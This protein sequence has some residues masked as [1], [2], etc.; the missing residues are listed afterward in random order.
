MN[1]PTPNNRIAQYFSPIDRSSA[2]K[3]QPP[4]ARRLPCTMA[5]RLSA[6]N[7]KHRAS[8]HD[9]NSA[10][11]PTAGGR[12]QS[13]SPADQASQASVTS[14]PSYGQPAADQLAD[15][16]QSAIRLAL[17]LLAG[18][19]FVAIALLAVLTHLGWLKVV[20]DPATLLMIGCVGSLVCLITTYSAVIDLAVT[21][22][23]H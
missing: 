15:L 21:T 9:W 2:K 20:N 17:S 23:N 11:I 6:N 5:G 8:G 14:L 7:A 22:Q 1:T 10:P 16:C 4:A 12:R 18:G 19:A 13:H 3:S